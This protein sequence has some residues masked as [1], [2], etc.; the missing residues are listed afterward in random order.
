LKILEGG[1]MKIFGTICLLAIIAIILSSAADASMITSGGTILFSDDFEGAAGSLDT[2]TDRWYVGGT[3]EK[4]GSGNVYISPGGYIFPKVSVPFNVRLFSPATQSI[5]FYVGQVDAIVDNKIVSR[6]EDV[7]GE[8]GV[9]VKLTRSISHTQ[10]STAEVELKLAGVNTT[11]ATIESIGSPDISVIIGATTYDV[12]INHVQ[13]DLNGEAEG[14]SGVHGFSSSIIN[15]G[16]YAELDA[17]PASTG[18]GLY[19]SEFA[20]GY[21]P[22]PATLSL[23]SVGLLALLRK[24]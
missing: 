3:A 2:G 16:F 14:M 5:E 19:S 22:E 10:V 9:H 13:V 12:Y 18:W 24:K 11:I 1:K 23:L 15:S 8:N 4:D 17:P 20:V 7:T 21:V 6:I